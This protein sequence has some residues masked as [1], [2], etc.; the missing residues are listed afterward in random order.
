MSHSRTSLLVVFCSLAALSTAQAAGT[1][2]GSVVDPSGRPIPRAHVRVL[3]ASGHEISSTYADEQGRFNAEPA[4]NCRVEASLEGFEP[5]ATACASSALRLQLAVA[6]VAE[7]V[8]VTATATETPTSQIGASVSVFNEQDLEAERVPLVADLL[9]TTPGAMVVHTGAPGGVT[10]LFVRGGESNYNKVLIDGIPV[11]EPGGTFNFSNVTTD[12]LERLEIV[13]GAQSALFGSDA[14]ASVV[15]LI[16]KHGDRLNPGAHATVSFEGGTFNTYDATAAVSGSTRTLDY[17]L[18]ASQ[19]STDNQGPNAEL[20]NTGLSLNAG[21]DLG[22][23]AT[24]RAIGRAE[25]QHSGVPGQTVLYPVD[26][27]AFFERHDGLGGVT[28]DQNASSSFHEHVVYSY[29]VSNQ[30][31]TDLTSQSSNDFPYDSTT[32]LRRHYASYQAD[33][34]LRRAAN[35]DHVVTVLADWTGE[36]IHLTDRMPFDPADADSRHSRNNVGAAIQEQALWSRVFVTAG[37][38]IEHN[39]NFGTAA[40]PRGSLVFVAHE[41]SGSLG[42]TRVHVNGGLGIKE[43]TAL[44][45]FSTN[46]FFKGNPNLEPERSKSF[47]FGIDQRFASDRAKV[48]ATWFDNRFNNQITL[49]NSVYVNI[50]KTRAKGAEV[51]LDVA[52]ASHLHVNANYTYLDS[53]VVANTSGVGV[54][55]ELLRRPK[56][57]GSLGATLSVS[58]V[59]VNVN[60]VI[61]GQYMDNDFGFPVARTSN[62]GYGLWNARAS[63]DVLKR[64]SILVS[65]DNLSDTSYEE[66][67]GYPG[68]GRA[69]RVGARVK[70]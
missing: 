25:I 35:A 15:Q 21:L 39:Q 65:V 43:P 30:Q 68:L 20:H 13:R 38:R 42:E 64:L 59:T 26:T 1:I 50:N 56:N 12:N 7:H 51:G 22:H 67:L 69:V 70:F 27:D 33:L 34:H 9:R 49:V 2:T 46:A 32:N 48:E 19:L 6:P 60:G 24:L 31:S 55:T 53:S 63:I 40:V 57:S 3:D 36:R 8:S 16:T 44:Q 61:I 18:G 11:N 58:T 66:P 4:E 17:S 52:P 45:S 37:G 47:E 23:G 14:M 28:F 41:A 10:S 29:G 62:P 5:A 54:G